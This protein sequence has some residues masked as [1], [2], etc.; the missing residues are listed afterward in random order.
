MTAHLVRV[1]EFE[2]FKLAKDVSSTEINTSVLETIRSLD[3]REEVEPYLRK[4]ISDFSQTPHGPAELVDIFTHRLTLQKQ[5]KL[6][7]FII[8]GRS[9]KTVRPSDVGHQIYRLEKI[10]GLDVAIFAASGVILDQAKEQFVSTA[11]RCVSEYSIADAIDLAKIF[12]AYGFICPKDGH[13]IVAGRC[14]CGY[15]P[16]KRVLNLF[17]IETLKSL[18][19][20]RRRRESAGLVVL[21]P[22]SGKTRVAAEDALS[23]NAQCVLY[24][25]H[26]HE[27]LDVAKSEF[28]AKFGVTNV[29]SHDGLESLRNLNQVNLV[30]VQLLH[31]Y[32]AQANLAQV[33]YAV[34]DEFHHA[35]AKTYRMILQAISPTYLLGLTA[36]PFRGDN[37]DVLRLCQDNQIVSFDLRSGVNSGILS[38]YHYFGCFD[39]VN[40]SDIRYNNSRYDIR[41]LER[42]LL[43]PERDQA[44]IKKWS[45]LADGKPTIAF[46]CTHEHALR[47]AMSFTSAGIS[48][49]VYI[50]STPSDERATLLDHLA[51]GQIS[52]LC[53]VDIFNEGADL[54]FIECLLFLR[55]SESKRILYQQLGRGLRQYVGKKQCIAIDF[56][57]N[58]KNAYRIVEYLGLLPIDEAPESLDVIA[59]AR[60]R[61]D[62]LNL[63]LGCEVD[64]DD[65][66][67][68][69]FIDQTLDPRYATRHNIRRILLYQYERLAR[70]MYRRPTKQDIDRNC[71]LNSDLYRLAFGSWGEFQRIVDDW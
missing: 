64:F 18:G 53:V 26:T 1:E 16:R 47:M 33:D 6:A 65:R 56:I 34:I 38:P 39:N 23:C 58:F 8:K 50:S 60:N 41:D 67:I 59:K 15:A 20:S 13:R 35:A 14:T 9:F 43:I 10:D 28:E 3:E 62:I 21:P 4:I 52:V 29:T 46:C 66:V 61:K 11:R 63:P 25:A 70:R 69:I 68:D 19:D 12:I 42:A 24:I 71:V 45:E 30:T 57:G 36:T 54:P 48:A 17:Q 31:R 22:G 37:Q 51:A 7:A 55:P 27:I 49:G 44:I 5:P 2:E 32:L 40:Y